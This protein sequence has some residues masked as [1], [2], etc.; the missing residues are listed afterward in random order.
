MLSDG[1]KLL[2]KFHL[3]LALEAASKPTPTKLHICF[4]FFYLQIVCQ[5]LSD[6]TV[7]LS[8]FQILLGIGRGL[9][10]SNPTPSKILNFLFFIFYPIEDSVLGAVLQLFI[11][12]SFLGLAGVYPNVFIPKYCFRSCQMARRCS[13]NFKFF[14]ALEGAYPLPT[15][16]PLKYTIFYSLFSIPR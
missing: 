2:S 4:V 3:F 12:K 16:P 7:L 9:P 13:L 15:Q 14:L 5:V 6:G 1:T 11:F 8:K 10:P